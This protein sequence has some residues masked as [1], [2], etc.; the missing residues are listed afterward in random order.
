MADIRLTETS[1]LPSKYVADVT[2]R[3]SELGRQ[4]ALQHTS[5]AI[6]RPDCAYLLLRQ[7]GVGLGE[8]PSHATFDRG[9]SHVLLVSTDEQIAWSKAGRVVTAVAYLQAGWDGT[10][11]QLVGEPVDER[12]AESPVAIVV[13]RSGPLPTPRWGNEPTKAQPVLHRQVSADW[14]GEIVAEAPSPVV[15]SAVAAG[16]M[17]SPASRYRA[18]TL[19][20]VAPPVRCGHAPGRGSGAGALSLSRTTDRREEDP[21]PI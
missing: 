14:R 10:D 9:V 8:P 2:L 3:H 7:F 17:R 15:R 20:H 16:Q 6:A 21:S 4:L 5:S 1:P 13:D 19:Y 11:P 18:R 12:A